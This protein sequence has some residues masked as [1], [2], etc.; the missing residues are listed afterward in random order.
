MRPS[1]NNHYHC[2]NSLV[3]RP[4]ESL[5]SPA[6]FLL[7][8][9]QQQDTQSPQTQ[10]TNAIIGSSSYPIII[11]WKKRRAHCCSPVLHSSSCCRTAAASFNEDVLLLLAPSRLLLSHDRIDKWW[12]SHRSLSANY[13]RW[14]K[15]KQQNIT[16]GS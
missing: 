12:K 7:P 8:L 16:Q 10:P 9:Q 5:P 6:P 1:K 13:F 15:N 4:L 11:V 3:D 2:C 14:M